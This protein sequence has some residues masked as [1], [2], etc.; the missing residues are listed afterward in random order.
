MNVLTCSSVLLFIQ[1]LL[2]TGSL[3][4]NAIILVFS[5]DIDIS[6][7]E[8]VFC[9]LYIARC[10]IFKLENQTC[11]LNYWGRWQGLT[12]GCCE[13]G[14]ESSGSKKERN[15]LNSWETIGF[16]TVIPSIKLVSKQE[17]GGSVS[18]ASARFFTFSISISSAHKKQN[19]M[20]YTNIYNIKIDHFICNISCNLYSI[21]THINDEGI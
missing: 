15:F 21:F 10:M 14:N 11:G 13:H 18:S 20:H 6:K 19:Y 4:E 3:P 8:T 1:I 2:L 9:R 12:A 17:V 7:S 16:L 5:I